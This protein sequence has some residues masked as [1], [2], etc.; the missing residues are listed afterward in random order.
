MGIAASGSNVALASTSAVQIYNGLAAGSGISISNVVGIV[1]VTD[2]WLV[3]T[4]TT[5][6]AVSL[7]PLGSDGTLGASPSLVFPGAPPSMAFGPGDLVLATW[8]SGSGAVTTILVDA[9]GD[10][11]G[12]ASSVFFGSGPPSVTTDGDHFFVGGYGISTV[13]GGYG[14]G[15]VVK[16]DRVEAAYYEPAV[17]SLIPSMSESQ[18]AYLALP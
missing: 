8:L 11:I 14:S 12:S 16:W 3:A 6:D 17:G 5:D 10:A 2:G 1:G 4:M 9:S 15:L 7:T 13:I 18:L